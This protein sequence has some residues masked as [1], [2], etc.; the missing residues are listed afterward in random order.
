MY[1]LANKEVI[2]YVSN[3][4]KSLEKSFENFNF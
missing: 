4:R 3:E 1:I 2:F